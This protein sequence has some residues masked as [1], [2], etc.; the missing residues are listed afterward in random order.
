MIF[1][2][3]A[4]TFLTMFEYFWLRKR[5]EKEKALFFTI[6]ITSFILCMGLSAFM[7]VIY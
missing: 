4:T 5:M 1:I 6:L 2:F 3:L 7:K